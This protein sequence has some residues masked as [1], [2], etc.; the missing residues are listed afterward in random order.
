MSSLFIKNAS[1]LTPTLPSTSSNKVNRFSL[2]IENGR[3]IEIGDQLKPGKL[4][5]LD[6]EGLTLTPGWIDIQLNG[7]F[8]L[9]FTEEP[10]NIWE[11]AKKLPEL[12]VTSFLPTIISSPLDIPEKAI[13][14]LKNK[15]QGECEASIPIGL[16][17]EGPFLN[18]GK[19]GAHNPTYL[20]D[21]SPE[22]VSHW[23]RDNG[24][25][26]VTLAPELD[27]D[28]Q[29]IKAL[30]NQK[31]VVSAGHSLATYEQANLA[32]Y[33]GISCGTHLFNAQP[34]IEHRNPGISIA[35]LNAPEVYTGLIVDGVH[36]HP[37][38]VKL[39]WTSKG[40]QRFVTVT[41][42]ISALGMP[43]GNY[44][45]GEFEIIVTQTKVTLMDG[46]LAGSNITLGQSLRNLIAWTGCTLY[47]AVRTV[48]ATPAE[49]LNLPSKGRITVGADADL[50]LI[51]S[52]LDILATIVGGKILY[53]SF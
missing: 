12:G 26:L 21:P 13:Q 18:P 15:P 7:A 39:A 16:H 34:T 9:D 48:T 19:K 47:E 50:T 46:T 42:A 41:D 4:P 2:I 31:V 8:G 14:I 49:L 11:A 6:A 1:V 27:K 17:L 3:I 43:P 10:E 36:S 23:S 45:L 35:L 22:L 29:T 25:L 24:V 53:K 40:A 44:K 52:N 30:R 38:M 28:H 37:A 51:N 33:N 5:I 32:F 20:L